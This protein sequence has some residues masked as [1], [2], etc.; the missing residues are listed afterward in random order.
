[1]MKLPFLRTSLFVF[2]AAWATDVSAARQSPTTG[3]VVDTDG[4]A[5]AYATVVLLD[6]QT[7]LAGTA[8]AAD[9]SFTLKA[10]PLPSLN[11]CMH[12]KSCMKTGMTI[13]GSTS[14]LPITLLY[15]P[16]ILSSASGVSNGAIGVNRTS[17]CP[18]G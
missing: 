5:I 1:M 18:S 11:G 15:S 12:R 4:T 9:G 6:G 2:F 7:Q 16:H 17:V 14:K 3:R 8:T 10:L 13:S